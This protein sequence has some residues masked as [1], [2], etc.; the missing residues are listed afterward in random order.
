MRTIKQLTCLFLSLTLLL[1]IPGSSLGENNTRKVS[2]L[3]LQ[4]IRDA[5]GVAVFS[6]MLP[7]SVIRIGFEYP[8]DPD[9]PVRLIRLLCDGMLRWS[10]SHSMPEETGLFAGD[11]FDQAKTALVFRAASSEMD[12]FF[13]SL[14]SET[15]TEAAAT[16]LSPAQ[17]LRRFLPD[18]AGS[19][20]S[21]NGFVYDDGKAFSLNVMHQEDCLMT[22]SADLSG[23]DEILLVLGQ[24]DGRSF[25]YHDLIIRGS[26]DDLDYD[27]SLHHSERPIFSEDR[28]QTLVRLQLECTAKEDGWNFQGFLNSTIFSVPV[29]LSGKMRTIADGTAPA[30]G[31]Q[32]MTGE[33]FLRFLQSVTEMTRKITLPVP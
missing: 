26:S 9:L 2:I 19:G 17:M 8:L 22:L 4:L 25:F 30:E 18:A 3:K 21:L 15:A 33:D 7:K 27:Y 28:L 14:S 5:E 32:V 13:D 12:A 29:A 23:A 16:D 24:G 1:V 11:A 6:S 10:R 31:Y 20:T